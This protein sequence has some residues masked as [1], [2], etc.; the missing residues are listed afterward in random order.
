MSFTICIRT[1]IYVYLITII[2]MSSTKNATG[3]QI[4]CGQCKDTASKLYYKLKVTLNRSKYCIYVYFLL[5]V[6]MIS[7]S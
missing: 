4:F 6:I 2:N 7:H 3:E 1:H 5:V